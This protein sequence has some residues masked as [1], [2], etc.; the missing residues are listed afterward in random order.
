MFI[1]IWLT[2]NRKFLFF[3]SSVKIYFKGINDNIKRLYLLL[4][5]SLVILIRVDRLKKKVNGFMEENRRYSSMELTLPGYL[6]RCYTPCYLLTKI[7]YLPMVWFCLIWSYTLA[8]WESIFLVGWLKTIP[9]QP[10]TWY[11]CGQ[12]VG[13]PLGKLLHSH[14][15]P[16]LKFGKWHRMGATWAINGYVI[17][18]PYMTHVFI[19]LGKLLHSTWDPYWNLESGIVWVLH[20]Q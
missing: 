7:A 9:K 6:W 3:N 17:W 5:P 8:I 15:G 20:G 19:P 14:M 12:M 10:W 18:G 13:I 16:I 1:N 4:L 2:P 11:P